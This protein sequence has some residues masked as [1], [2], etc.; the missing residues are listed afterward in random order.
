MPT[1]TEAMQIQYAKAE[2]ITALIQK[3]GMP[4]L[5][6]AGALA[7]DA[8][9]NVVLVHDTQARR[10]KIKQLVRRLDVPIKQVV[11]DVRVVTM[12]DHTAEDFGL[13]WGFTQQDS[14]FSTTGRLEGLNDLN[15]SRPPEGSKGL[16][17]NL[18]AMPNK[19]E[20][21]TVAMR[22]AVFDPTIFRFELLLLSKSTPL[23]SWLDQELPPSIT[24]RHA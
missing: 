18:P 14:K 13:R 7:F 22:W 1:T 8:R 19:G 12:R 5:S 11:I 15:A 4:L 24:K 21:A 20:A 23:K 6:K 9:T 3:S 10:L 2:Q 17:V 16:N